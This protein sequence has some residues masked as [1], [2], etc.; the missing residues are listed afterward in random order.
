MQFATLFRSGLCG[1]VNK[2]GVPRNTITPETT[3]LSIASQFDDTIQAGE[4]YPNGEPL[5]DIV[6]HHSAHYGSLIR[7]RYG[8]PFYTF[9]TMRVEW[10]PEMVLVSQPYSRC[11][12]S[13]SAPRM[14][15][16]PAEASVTR[17]VR[18]TITQP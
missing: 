10:A 18:A 16:A 6:R 2:L 11:T 1:A 13:S 14:P 17:K 8:E 3:S 7:C 5:Y 15:S 4:V 12:G 9:E